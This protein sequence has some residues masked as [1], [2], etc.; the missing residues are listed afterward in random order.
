MPK[1]CAAEEKFMISYDS[2]SLVATTFFLIVA[3][4]LLF[5]FT[6]AFEEFFF[7]LTV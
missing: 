6:G 7:I 2:R 3:I 1:S 4:V 5:H